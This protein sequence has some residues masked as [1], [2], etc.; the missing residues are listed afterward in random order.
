VMRCRRR[1]EQAQ[2]LHAEALDIFREL[3]DGWSVALS[4]ANLGL[5]ALSQGI[6]E[7]AAH[8]FTESIGMFRELGVKQGIATCLEGLAE[9]A[10]R[11]G[12]PER[13]TTLYGAADALREATVAI[14]PPYE[15]ADYQRG[16]AFTRAALN[17]AAFA[18]AWERGRTIDVDQAVEMATPPAL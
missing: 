16:L 3:N 5:V 11:A 2:T 18:G 1:F 15:D 12:D 10:T 17:D 8:L 13:A 9:V 6:E 7:K 4:L 14:R